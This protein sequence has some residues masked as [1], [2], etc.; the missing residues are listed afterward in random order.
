MKSNNESFVMADAIPW[1]VVDKGIERKIL[2]YNQE[3]MMVHVRFEKGGI[4]Q[5]HHHF[6]RQISYILSGSFEVE[7]GGEKR[8]LKQGDSYIVEPDVVHGVIALED[9]AIIDV[10]NPIREDFI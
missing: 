6:H 9:S 5:L 8:I 10:F 7:I 1:Q 4:G 2:C 3:Q